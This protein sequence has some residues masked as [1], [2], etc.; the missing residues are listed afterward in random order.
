MIASL[1]ADGMSGNH[2]IDVIAT[3]PGDLA[4]RCDPVCAI[5]VAVWL[6][7]SAWNRRTGEH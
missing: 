7:T 6:V 5:L 1:A 4:A 2:L 3:G